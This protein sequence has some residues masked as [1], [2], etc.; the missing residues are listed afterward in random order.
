MTASESQAQAFYDAAGFHAMSLKFAIKLWVGS[1]AIFCAVLI[2]AG[3]M[4]L[5]HSH[6]AW[7]KTVW[8][9]SVLGL[10]LVVMLVFIILS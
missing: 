4:H 6:S 1:V 9:L 8:M 3:L 7:D 10:S 5:L 2:L